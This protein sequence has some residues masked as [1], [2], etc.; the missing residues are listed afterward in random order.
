MTEA[1]GCRGLGNGRRTPTVAEQSMPSCNN[2]KLE[3]KLSYPSRMNRIILRTVN[4][5]R[6]QKAVNLVCITSCSSLEN[7]LSTTSRQSGNARRMSSFPFTAVSLEK[8]GSLVL[9]CVPPL[10]LAEVTR[11][12]LPLL[13]SRRGGGV[14]FDTGPKSK[15]APRFLAG[16]EDGCDN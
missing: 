6:R 8:G 9:F 15:V 7:S 2:Q 3:A 10:E 14:V 12:L 4:M 1:R 5:S 13:L 11:R 16:C